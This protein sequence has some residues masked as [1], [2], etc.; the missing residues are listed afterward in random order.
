MIRI[1]DIALK[2]LLQ[3]SRDFKTFMFLLI[4]PIVF[5]L[6]FGYAFGGFGGAGGDARIPVGFL[7]HDHSR[8]SK[9]LR[10]I[11]KESKVIRLDEDDSRAMIDLEN[12]IADNKVAAA[13]IV[14]ADYGKMTLDGK[15]AKLIFIGD[16]ASPAGTT[17]QSEI[18]SAASRLDSAIRTALIMEE[19]AKNRTPFDYAF[20]PRS[21]R[22]RNRPSPSKKQP[23]RSF[24]KTADGRCR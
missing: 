20:I 16:A 5:T 14:P 22:G 11:L 13:V 9:S 12:L 1:F 19:V 15:S 8:F 23:A 17:I 18:I 6:L 24:A 4:M 21:M 7:D 10:E 3:L 2:D